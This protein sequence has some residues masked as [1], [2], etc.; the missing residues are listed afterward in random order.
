MSGRDVWIAG[1]FTVFGAFLTGTYQVAT[2]Q[3]TNS[4]ALSRIHTSISVEKASFITGQVERIRNPLISDDLKRDYFNIL[5][6]I[7]N[8]DERETLSTDYRQL[9]NDSN[10]S[11]EILARA[12]LI[13]ESSQ[14]VQEPGEES[15]DLLA[16]R[17]VIF[18]LG[19]S[20]FDVPPMAPAVITR[21]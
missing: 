17:R 2:V 14:I 13:S 16:L 1:A 20:G 15:L 19:V 6:T 9:D 10:P 5:L 18:S 3:I 7:L 8:E 12:L 21:V 4:G 11:I